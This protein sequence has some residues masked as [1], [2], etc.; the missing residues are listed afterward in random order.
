MRADGA[1]SRPPYQRLCALIEVLVSGLR[2]NP[3]QSGAF[4]LVSPAAFYR[5]SESPSAHSLPHRPQ[6]SP[7]SDTDPP[8]GP[9]SL[10]LRLPLPLLPPPSNPP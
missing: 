7:L 9:P 5:P 4:S 3:R 8:S 2:T 10:P 6:P 1:V